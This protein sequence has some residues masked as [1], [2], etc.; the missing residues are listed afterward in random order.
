MQSAKQALRRLLE[1]TGLGFE[2][3]NPGTVVIRQALGTSAAGSADLS[4]AQRVAD[5][6]DLRESEG[7][8]FNPVAAVAPAPQP[9]VTADSSAASDPLVSEVIVTA[10]KMSESAKDVPESIT[11]LSAQ[12]LEKFNIQSFNDYATKVPNLGFSYGTGGLGFA[13]SR[14]IAIRGISGQGT[15]ALYIDDTP[16]FDNM[17]PRVVD[18]ERVEVLKGPQGTLFGEG[19]LG[20]NVRLI[21]KQ[22]QMNQYS[23]DYSG[24]LGKTVDG[25]SPEGA[26]NAVINAGL[27]PDTIAVRAL[28]FYD[29]TPGFITRRFPTGAGGFQSIDDQGARSD[30]GGSLSVL[31]KVT[32]RLDMT[33]RILT[34]NTHYEGLPVAYAPLPGFKVVSFIQDRSTNIQEGAADKWYLPSLQLNFRGWGFDVVSA[35]TYFSRNNEDTENGTEGTYEAATN[36]FG[37][38][39]T[40]QPD[41][42]ER[43][44][45]TH[46][47]THETRLSFE[48]T[49]RLSGTFG[50]YY[51]RTNDTGVILPNYLPGLAAAGFFPTDLDWS[52]TN[53]LTTEEKAVFGELY[54]DLPYGNI[55]TLGARQYWLNQDTSGVA[56]G[57]FNGGPSATSGSNSESGV[58]PK[59]AL[60]HKIGDDSAAYVSAAKGFRAGGAG[61]QLPQFCASGLAEIGLTTESAAKF[62]PDTVWNYEVGAKSELLDRQ[63]FVTGALFQQNW[64]HIQQLLFIPSCGFT[65]EGNAGS[66]RSRGAELEASGHI[67]PPLL[68]RAG[69]GYDDAVITSSGASG[70]AVG[71]RVRETPKLTATAGFEYTT[72]L[73][74]GL[75][76]FISG[77][78]S[79]VGDSLSSVSSASN[80]LV[81]PAYNLVNGRLG[82]RWGVYEVALFMKNLTNAKPNL[83]DLN[84]ISYSRYVENAQGESVI[85]P[86]VATLEPLTFGIQFRGSF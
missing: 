27:V 14:T 57:I 19:S 52:S 20:G 53:K 6:R 11:A 47:L 44:Q 36:Y 59:F 54:V 32:D 58:S 39:A 80:I 85:L 61:G 40:P 65:F 74:T 3:I 51:S 67:A 73:T 33:A 37:F 56:D 43:T 29:H 34:Q 50:V 21:T 42:W 71:S 2:I 35:T 78:Y 82:V 18:V 81:R 64:Q 46:R 16:V 55:V 1:G 24:E 22:P 17:D 28:L 10:R 9:R 8:A 25:G 76:G 84:P 86:R 62:D 7:G 60:E 26:L 79:H 30:Y 12:T 23:V 66:A 49:H 75:Q 5:V 63:L 72:P 13:T 69:V 70:E 83:G 4:K 68:I 31:F 38:N 77:D 48:E 15:T 41:P 45:S